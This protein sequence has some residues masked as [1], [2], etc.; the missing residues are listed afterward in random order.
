MRPV[1]AVN[2]VAITAMW[3]PLIEAHG[4]RR[5]EGAALSVAG[6]ASLPFDN[7]YQAAPDVSAYLKEPRV[8]EHC[9]P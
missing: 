8:V 9:T 5:R 1:I 6:L 7:W 2:K 4:R 3:R